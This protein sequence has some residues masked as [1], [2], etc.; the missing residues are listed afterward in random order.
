MHH[1]GGNQS[2]YIKHF[3]RNLLQEAFQVWIYKSV[4]PPDPGFPN[5]CT[6][7]VRLAVVIAYSGE[8]LACLRFT[9]T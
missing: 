2:Q 3:F 8:R 9:L 6:N 7:S 5:K 1:E 4:R